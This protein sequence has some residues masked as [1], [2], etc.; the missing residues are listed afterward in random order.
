MQP[1]SF[2]AINPWPEAL[3]Y[4][5]LRQ[6]C[7]MGIC[8]QIEESN[9]REWMGFSSDEHTVAHGSCCRGVDAFV[10][11]PIATLGRFRQCSADRSGGRKIGAGGC[12]TLGMLLE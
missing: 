9:S 6:F 7:S 11:F 5:L 4:I 10:V 1:F 2:G 12:G 8:S 3:G